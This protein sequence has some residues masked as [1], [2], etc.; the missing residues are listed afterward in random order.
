MDR[1]SP[2]SSLLLVVDVQEKLLVAMPDE[3][4]LR[5]VMP[6]NLQGMGQ[7]PLTSSNSLA[8][9]TVRERRQGALSSSS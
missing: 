6:E 3:R 2:D 9:R 4:F 1:L 5:F 7:I 8:V